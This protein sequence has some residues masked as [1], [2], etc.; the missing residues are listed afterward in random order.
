MVVE[1]QSYPCSAWLPLCPHKVEYIRLPGKHRSSSDNSLVF[2]MMKKK[3]A[4]HCSF[5]T[6]GHYSD[7]FCTFFACRVYS[8]DYI[9]RG[10]CC[11][12][13][14]WWEKQI[15]DLEVREAL[16]INH[17]YH[18]LILF[19]RQSCTAWVD[20]VPLNHGLCTY[21]GHCLTD[22]IHSPA[23]IEC[24]DPASLPSNQTKPVT[25]GSS[26]YDDNIRSRQSSLR[27]KIH[28]ILGFNVYYW[29]IP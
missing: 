17:L 28:I 4:L 21:E 29:Y 23:N 22:G 20:E 10:A 2:L 27:I 13:S 3:S 14:S 6:F 11:Q 12:V 19:S 16:D 24:L 15:K 1:S 5:Y 25:I 9:Y 18:R 7:G 26:V 8:I